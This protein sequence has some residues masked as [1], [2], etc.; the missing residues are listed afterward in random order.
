MDISISKLN[1]ILTPYFFWYYNRNEN[2][3]IFKTLAKSVIDKWL[4]FC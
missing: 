4:V 3:I 1:K 2:K